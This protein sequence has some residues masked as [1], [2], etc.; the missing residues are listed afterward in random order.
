MTEAAF[1]RKI[2][3]RYGNWSD[4]LWAAHKYCE[5]ASIDYSANIETEKHSFSGSASKKIEV[6]TFEI[7]GSLKVDFIPLDILSEFPNLNGISIVFYNLPALKSGFFKSE[8]EKIEYLDL[9]GNQIETIEPNAFQ[10]LIKLKWV[11]LST[12]K[13]QA[14]SHK[15]F[16]NNPGLIYMDLRNNQINSIHPNFFDGLQKLKLVKLSGNLCIQS[17]IGCETCLI[18]EDDLKKELKSCFDNWKNDS[19]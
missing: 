5:T 19:D 16:E 6:K 15:L 8:L 9:K 12:N 2:E 3:C 18:T 17:D 4:T 7:S 10:H 14:L 1:G 13:L 11:L